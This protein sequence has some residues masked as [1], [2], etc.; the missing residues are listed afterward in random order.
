MTEKPLHG[1]LAKKESVLLLKLLKKNYFIATYLKMWPFVKPIWFV[2]LISVLI[3]VPIGALDATIALFLKPYTDLVIVSNNAQAPWYLPFLIVGFT[4]V[5]GLL[6]Y[7]SAYLSAYA[8]GRLTNS[9][10]EAL[11]DKLIQLDSAYYDKQNSGVI[12]VRFSGDAGTAS[13]GLL[14]NAKNLVTRVCST[15]ALLCVLIYTSWKLALIA[16]VILG[17]TVA[18]L[19]MVRRLLKKIVERTIVISQQLNVNYNETYAGN[20]TIR[21]YNLQENQRQSFIKHVEEGFQLGLKSVRRTAWISPFMHFSVSVGVSLTI[22]YGSWLIVHNEMT[23]GDFVAFLAA[24]LMMYTPIKSLGSTITHMQGSFLAIERIFEIFAIEP[25][26]KEK[27]DCKELV[28]F[29]DKICFNNVDFEYKENIPVLRK[30]N[31]TIEKNQAIALVGNSG[32]GK[33]TI[34]SLLPRF[35]DVVGGSISIDGTD[36]RDF[37]IKSL[38][39]QISIV[40]QD[41][42]LFNGTIRE[43]ILFGRKDSTE[44]EL[45]Y[46]VKSAYL[47]DFI[48]ELPDGLETE[49]GERGTLLSGG[50]KQRVAIARA[51]LRNAPIL[52]LDEATSAL[53]NKSEAIVQQAIENL[54]ENKTVIIIAHRLST[55][56]NADK[57]AFIQEGEMIEFGTH[58]ELMQIPDG[59]Y[60]NLYQLQF[61][62]QEEAVSDTASEIDP[63]AVL[64]GEAKEK[65]LA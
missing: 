54:M 63:D 39:D 12:L 61:K 44:E 35:Y 65:V 50:Q 46:A 1:N 7:A 24:L 27:E 2:S 11:Y 29:K 16:V 6:I 22:A 36:I 19:T 38:R 52:I 42:F 4:I 62:T 25:A 20:K 33:S 34:I 48:A 45:A 55:I 41:N 3:G 13:A 9:V 56:K 18:P 14:G 31:L 57:I 58:E 51:F 28:E 43:N 40:F 15:L 21:A 49:I 64:T 10:R 59:F 60:K 8:G 53:D 37:S 17:I 23:A 26:I 30:L 32:G 47:E 5:Q